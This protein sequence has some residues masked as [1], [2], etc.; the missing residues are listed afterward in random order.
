[1]LYYSQDE[2]ILTKKRKSLLQDKVIRAVCNW[3]EA[4]VKRNSNLSK[5]DSSL[6][7]FKKEVSIFLKDSMNQLHCANLRTTTD[8]SNLYKIAKKT[9]IPCD[10]LPNGLSIVLTSEA[11]FYFMQYSQDKHFIFPSCD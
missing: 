7:K 5:T 4:E 6:Q 11:A 9:H 10:A 1:M 8:D 2:I 3:L